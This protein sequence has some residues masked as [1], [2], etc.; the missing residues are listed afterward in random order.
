MVH[1]QF[2]PLLFQTSHS[3]NSCLSHFDTFK[4]LDTRHHRAL[5]AANQ[6]YTYSSI[7]TY[8]FVWLNVVLN[9]APV[10]TT[11]AYCSCNTSQQLARNQYMHT[12]CDTTT[13][14]V[15]SHQLR[16]KDQCLEYYLKKQNIQNNCCLVQVYK[17]YV[18]CIKICICTHVH[19]S[20]I[21]RNDSHGYK[22]CIQLR[23]Y[24]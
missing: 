11:A 12:E 3:L 16:A 13:N 5:N 22:L 1:P 20:I 23:L 8:R 4:Q 2:N 6:Q 18:H 10:I 15:T 9:Y 7:C 17:Y 14:S 24:S 21:H 19:V